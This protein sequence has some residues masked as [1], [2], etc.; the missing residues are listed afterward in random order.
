MSLRK[1]QNDLFQKVKFCCRRSGLTERSG[2]E[3]LS[4][5]PVRT[6]TSCDLLTDVDELDDEDGRG[7][8]DDVH[9]WKNVSAVC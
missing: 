8:E 4:G 9:N 2:C 1:R 7:T 3:E 6:Q 5:E